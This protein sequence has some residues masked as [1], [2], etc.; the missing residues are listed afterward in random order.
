MH[1]IAP[2]WES[3]RDAH[4]RV[5]L[6]NRE[7]EVLHKVINK[8]GDYPDLELLYFGCATD[9]FYRMLYKFVWKT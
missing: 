5:L 9:D 1:Q 6:E 7:A 2:E 3:R 8:T 4:E